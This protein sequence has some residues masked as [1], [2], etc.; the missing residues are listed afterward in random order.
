M[1]ERAAA[2]NAP[3]EILIVENSGHNWREAGGELQ[4][5]FKEIVAKTAAFMQTQLDKNSRR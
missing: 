5:T 3:V 1:K 4:P 2:V